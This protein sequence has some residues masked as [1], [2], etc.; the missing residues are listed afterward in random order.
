MLCLSSSSVVG[1]GL[2]LVAL[3]LWVVVTIVWVKYHVCCWVWAA[4]V[5]WVQDRPSPS[6]WWVTIVRVKYPV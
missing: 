6:G 3:A 2:A 5:W 4:A 1:T